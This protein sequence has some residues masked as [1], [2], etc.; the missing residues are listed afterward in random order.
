MRRNKPPIPMKIVHPI[1][2]EFNRKAAEVDN[3][4]NH[5]KAD[6]SADADIKYMIQDLR[7]MVYKLNEMF[8]TGDG[9]FLDSLQRLFETGC[10]LAD[11]GRDPYYRWAQYAFKEYNKIDDQ[12]AP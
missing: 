4:I 10:D 11:I 7:S 1:T 8:T 9:E 5:A 3:F 12:L 2:L 6:P